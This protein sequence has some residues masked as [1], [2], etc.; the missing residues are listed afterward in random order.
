MLT[1]IATTVTATH[2]VLAS[3]SPT[4][5]RVAVRSSGTAEDLAEASFAGMHDT[6][7][8]IHGVEAL[9]DAVKRCWASLWTAR[10]TS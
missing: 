10:A 7:L 6:Y 9:L 3:R 8:D 2:A 5:L 1:A 4:P